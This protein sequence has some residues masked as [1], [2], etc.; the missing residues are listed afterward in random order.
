MVLLIPNLQGH[1]RKGTA[2]AFLQRYEEAEEAFQA[3]LK[4]DP[5]NQQLQDALADVEAKIS[6]SFEQTMM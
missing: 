1:L 6:E 2:L 4:H 5:E 3:G